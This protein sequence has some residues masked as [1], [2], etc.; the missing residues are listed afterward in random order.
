MKEIKIKALNTSIFIDD[1]NES[2][3]GEI[4]VY[5]SRKEYLDY[6]EEISFEN[7]QE[8]LEEIDR[9]QAVKTVEELLQRF[10]LYENQDFVFV[11][12]FEMGDCVNIIGDTKILFF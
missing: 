7:E 11:E 12:D 3:D 4:R 1:L 9:L 8:Y 10:C 2:T 6:Y 5:D